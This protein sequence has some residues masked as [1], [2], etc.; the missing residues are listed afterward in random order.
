MSKLHRHIVRLMPLSLLAIALSACSSQPE[1]HS[2]AS[3]ERPPLDWSIVESN[4]EALKLAPQLVDEIGEKIFSETDARGMFMV[5]IDNNEVFHRSYGETRPG[6]GIK[7]R[8]DSLIRIASVS[9]LMT[10]EVM[11]KMADDGLVNLNDPLQK[12]SYKQS[13]VPSY[14]G[15][16]IR[17]F[18]LA[19]HTSILPREQPGGK[20]GRPV[21]TWPS[22]DQRW[23]WLKT[24]KLT[25]QPGTEAAYSNLA[26]DLLADALEKAGNR[27]YT[28][29]FRH[30]VTQ[31]AGMKDT[32]YNPSAAQCKR[33]MVGFK[34]SDCYSTLAAIGSGGVYSTPADMQK[35]MQRFLS[36]GNTQRKATATK[37]QTIYFKRGHL[38]EIKGMD[39][40]GEADGLGLGWVYLA[41]VGDIPAIYQKTGGGGGFNTYMAMIPEKNIGVFVV[42]TRKDGSKFSPLPNGVNDLVRSLAD[43][44]TRNY[45]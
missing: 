12:Y 31:P 24:A 20:W 3:A 38:N 21:F 25:A 39:V 32:T 15:K 2:T 34:P 28:E 43:L 42:M 13:S 45:L 6:N 37:E 33:L 19:S 26:Y 30:Y 41:P 44:H 5:V 14:N 8:T 4:P 23:T 40:A 1:K 18:H 11:V 22:R 9:K 36:S 29:L 27:P 7:P 16:P 35:W 17:L 10:S